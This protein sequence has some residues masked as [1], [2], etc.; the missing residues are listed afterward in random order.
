MKNRE[1]LEKKFSKKEVKR[2]PGREGKELFYIETPSVIKRLNEAFDGDWS[3]EVKEKEI[4]LTRG[5][6]WILGRLT[7][8]NI[9]KEQ[10]G[11]KAFSPNHERNFSD[12]GDDLKAATS[13]ALKKCATLLG[14]GL[15]LYEEEEELSP[16][17]PASEKQKQFIRNLLKVKGKTMSEEILAKLSFEEASKLIDKLK[18]EESD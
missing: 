17:R 12:F 4:D 1:I 10:F 2:R 15:Y 7:C 5:Y 6:I 3:F 18:N 11:F 16:T 14:V 8:G 9:V 13:D